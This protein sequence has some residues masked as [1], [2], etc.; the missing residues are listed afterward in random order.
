LVNGIL[1]TFNAMK[2]ALVFAIIT[3]LTSCISAIYAQEESD[4][5][6]LI[7][8]SG[9]VVTGDSLIPVPYTTVLIQNSRRGTICDH[10]GFFSLV[11]RENDV[12]VF[13]SIGYKA[14]KMTIPDTLT[15]NRYSLIQ[16]LMP[17][18]IVLPEAV[19]YPWPTYEQFKQAFITL[20]IPDDDLERARKNLTIASARELYE[21]VPMDGS[22]N[23]R[24]YTQDHSYRLYYA[25]QFPPNQLLNP[26]AWAKFIEAWRKGDFRRND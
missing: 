7:Q 2:K 12:I 15:G 22:M 9:I 25:G 26:F 17:D 21:G 11:V 3:L 19:I 16:L 10:L 4:E 20:K 23:Y 13:T 24:Q 5:P 6:V 18:T 8:L 14:S 1:I